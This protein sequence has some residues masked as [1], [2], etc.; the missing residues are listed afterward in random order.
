MIVQF[1]K[2][3]QRGS[4]LLTVSLLLFLVSA[5]AAG[6]VAL[7]T[8]ENLS[9]A[10]APAF[11][12]A[13]TVAPS[14]NPSASTD[15]L[16]PPLSLESPLEQK[17]EEMT[18]QLFEPLRQYYATKTERLKSVSVSVAKKPHFAEVTYVLSAVSATETH[19]FFYDLEKKTGR[20]PVWNLSLLDNTR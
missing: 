20:L 14:I 1:E 5:T 4:I 3:S 16:L 6:Y 8:N 19:T 18:Q 2:S 7:K 13:A 12:V 11:L 17:R 10:I 9:R 15:P